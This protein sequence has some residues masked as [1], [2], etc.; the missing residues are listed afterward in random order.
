M[1]NEAL[2]TGARNLLQ[3]CARV[4]LGERVLLVGERC[5]AP[6]FDARLCDDLAQVCKQLG[7]KTDIVLTEPGTD[8]A[9]F[10]PTVIRAMQ[11]ADVTLFFSRLGDQVRFLDSPGPGRKIM[12]YTLTRE[13]LAAPFAG[14]DYRLMQRVHDCLV[15][16]LKETE[17]I[18][19]EAGNGSSMVT[20]VPHHAGGEQALLIDF[21]L[22]LFPVMIFPPVNFHRLNGQL[23]LEHF[24][25]SSSTRAYADSVLILDTPVVA[26]IEDSRMVD[27]AGDAVLVK[28]LRAQ[29]E[30]AAAI[31][32]GDAYRLNSWHTGINPYT[33]FDGDPYADLERWGTVAYGSPRYTH[34]HAAGKDP[35]DISI[36]LFDASIRFDDQL[37]WNLGRFD[38]LDSPEV[39]ALLD[40][41]ERELLNASIRLEIGV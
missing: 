11:T 21:S 12:C 40:P 25:T 31:T 38:F 32:G 3:N 41:D 10:P 39:H 15:A 5:A 33:F 13:H 2:Q 30:R 14:V 36:Q 24:I 4:S 18:T 20:E 16:R 37:I 6:F 7:I 19:F 28:R 27:F 8:A 23:V 29:L 1:N 34:I 9:H 22:G 17:T 35:G 26:R